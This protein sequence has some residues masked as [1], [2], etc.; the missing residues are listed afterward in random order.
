MQYLPAFRTEQLASTL[1]PTAMFSEDESEIHWRM[2]R[3][4]ERVRAIMERWRAASGQTINEVRLIH[5]SLDGHSS[6]SQKWKE[7]MTDVIIFGLKLCVL[8]LKVIRKTPEGLN[9][10]I[11]LWEDLNRFLFCVG[12]PNRVLILYH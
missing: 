6:Y 9:T 2:N 7:A 12:R 8:F 5:R 3:Y 4:T 11:P 1:Q 10:L